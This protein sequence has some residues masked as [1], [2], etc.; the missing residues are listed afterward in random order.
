[1][2]TNNI[3]IISAVLLPV[4]VIAFVTW[5][6]LRVDATTTQ[7][8]RDNGHFDCGSENNSYKWPIRECILDALEICKPAYAKSHSDGVEWEASGGDRLIEV[9]R[10]SK[11]ECG[12][13]Y[14]ANGEAFF[15]SYSYDSFCKTIKSIG[16]QQQYLQVSDCEN[17]NKP[18]L[19]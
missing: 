10:N 1:M 11:G 14:I 6:F 7:Y 16:E 3:Y 2:K 8:V 19:F 18:Q 15:G 9:K 13:Q 4:V 17:I 12:V 5:Y